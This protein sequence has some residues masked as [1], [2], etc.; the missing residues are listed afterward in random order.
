MLVHLKLADANIYYISFDP[1]TN[2]VGALSCF[3]DGA[4][5]LRSNCTPPFDMAGIGGDLYICPFSGTLP[6]V[7]LGSAVPVVVMGA[8]F[9]DTLEL[10]PACPKGET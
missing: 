10:T 8:T 5:Y 6:F 9:S 2:C 3:G 7:G 1:T 4:T